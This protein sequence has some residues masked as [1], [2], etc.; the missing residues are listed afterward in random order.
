MDE[1]VEEPDGAGLVALS[2]ESV[3]HICDLG[4]V[5]EVAG[6]RQLHPKL[7]TW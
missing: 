5:T 3:E 6:R 1:E 7:E 2:L 4:P